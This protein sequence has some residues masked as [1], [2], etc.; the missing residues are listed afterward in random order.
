MKFGET[1]IAPLKHS[2]IKLIDSKEKIALQIFLKVKG[3]INTIDF[4]V[5]PVKFC[6]NFCEDLVRTYINS[7]MFI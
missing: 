1:E 2:E 3:K 7:P 4:I 5:P 6:T